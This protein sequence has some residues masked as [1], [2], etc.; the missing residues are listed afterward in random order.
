[1]R[2]I[3]FIGDKFSPHFIKWT[4][5]QK[6]I[7]FNTYNL[8]LEKKHHHY[9]IF[10]FYFFF[11]LFIK[12]IYLIKKNKIEILHCHYIGKYAFISYLLSFIKNK[13]VLTAWGSDINLKKNE[14]KNF[15]LRKIMEIII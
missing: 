15:F 9:S 3:L 11:K 7:G 6:K 14:I 12:G 4:K 1:M 13:L 10:S 2:S 5:T 8:S